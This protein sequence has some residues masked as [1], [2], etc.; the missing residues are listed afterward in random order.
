MILLWPP[1]SGVASGGTCPRAQVRGMQNEVPNSIF[2]WYFSWS[3]VA[4]VGV[5]G[6]S[7]MSSGGGRDA[8][9]GDR[10]RKEERWRFFC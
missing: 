5:S 8:M 6:I 3:R 9:F 1:S 10:G 4:R 2:T 7:Y